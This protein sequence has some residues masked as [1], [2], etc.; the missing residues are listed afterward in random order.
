MN[1]PE[2]YLIYINE[3]LLDLSKQLQIPGNYHP[4]QI[5]DSDS[6]KEIN[7]IYFLLKPLFIKKLVQMN[8]TSL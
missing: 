5:L 1:M 3:I 4:I 8:E 6:Q 2:W 7:L